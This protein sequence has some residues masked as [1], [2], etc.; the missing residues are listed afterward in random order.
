MLVNLLWVIVILVNLLCNNDLN[1]NLIVRPKKGG[2]TNLLK[3]TTLFL[4]CLHLLL[5]T[6]TFLK[7]VPAIYAPISSN[8]NVPL[9]VIESFGAIAKST[10]KESSIL[11]T[12]RISGVG[13]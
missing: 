7:L 2:N 11:I 10:I 6:P 5:N 9:I 3:D 1:T 12:G 13:K 4:Y 8:T